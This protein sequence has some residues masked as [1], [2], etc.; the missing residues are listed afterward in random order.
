MEVNNSFLLPS[1]IPINMIPLSDYSSSRNFEFPNIEAGNIVGENEDGILFMYS[2]TA[3][4]NIEKRADSTGGLSW[5]HADISSYL[6]SRVWNNRLKL[7]PSG[8]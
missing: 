6:A 1:K 4:G 8:Q 7:I 3:G 5:S 2:L